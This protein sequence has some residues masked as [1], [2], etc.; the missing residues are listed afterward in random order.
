MAEDNYCDQT[1]SDQAGM[2]PSRL[3]S[4]AD[5]IFAFA[6]TLLALS[7]NVP[8]GG[9]GDIGE[10]FRSQYRN[11]LTAFISFLVLAFF[12]QIFS[13]SF[14]H[15]RKT[16]PAIILLTVLMLFF[17]IIVP[18]STSLMNDYSDSVTAEIFFN[19]NLLILI[20]L[21]A[22]AWTYATGRD[23]LTLSPDSEHIRRSSKI[24]R[25]LPAIPLAATLISFITPG[26]SALIYLLVPAWMFLP[27][28]RK[29]DTPG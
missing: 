14:H 21:M 13:Q 29:K 5:A 8:E 27:L 23:M 6:M 18:F 24:I 10:F 1:D 25:L 22:L 2:T 11:F 26:W 15:I 16:D 3:E 19:G 4:L 17:V 9:I 20:S 28:F 12:W 7:I